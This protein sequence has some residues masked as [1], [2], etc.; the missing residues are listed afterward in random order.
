MAA[1]EQLRL[2]ILTQR[3]FFSPVLPCLSHRSQYIVEIRFVVEVILSSSSPP[4]TLEA[5][6]VDVF[7]ARKRSCRLVVWY[8][9]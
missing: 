3:L 2:H 6:A 4:R 8:H 7:T 1:V 9:L 5:A